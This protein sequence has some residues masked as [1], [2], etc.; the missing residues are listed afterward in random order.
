MTYQVMYYDSF[1]ME[2]E[3]IGSETDNLEEAIAERD[4]KNSANL[5]KGCI[6]CGD[7]YGVINLDSGL[8]E[9]CPISELRQSLATKEK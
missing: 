6:E 2:W 5:N 3:P 9:K 8:E 4:R 1:G 7:H